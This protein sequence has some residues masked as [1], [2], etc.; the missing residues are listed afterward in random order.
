ML[1]QIELLNQVIEKDAQE[2]YDSY[3]FKEVKIDFSKLELLSQGNFGEVYLYKGA[4]GK[5]F[6]IKTVPIYKM[7]SKQ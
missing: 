5:E 3:G 6:V 7:L 2:R 4:D 1:D